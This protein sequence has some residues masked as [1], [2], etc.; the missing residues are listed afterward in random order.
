MQ[1]LTA[2]QFMGIQSLVKNPLIEQAS[3]D[4]HHNGLLR[5]TVISVLNADFKAVDNAISEVFPGTEVRGTPGYSRNGDSEL[6][7]L[8]FE[9][10]TL[11]NLCMKKTPVGA[12]VEDQEVF[13]QVDYIVNKEC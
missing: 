9:G 10:E 1:E 4:F 7:F 8:D 12:G 3:I 13:T 5:V 11:I 6:W 2:A